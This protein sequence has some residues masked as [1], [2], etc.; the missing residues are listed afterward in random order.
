[1]HESV[2]FV[3]KVDYGYS[4]VV[5]SIS[6][7]YRQG[8]C[9]IDSR[10]NRHSSPRV[11]ARCKSEIHKEYIHTTV[12]GSRHRNNNIITRNTKGSE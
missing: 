11:S 12:D 7:L 4:L 2:G 10:V 8:L 6:L 1:M 5:M 3:Y 9:T